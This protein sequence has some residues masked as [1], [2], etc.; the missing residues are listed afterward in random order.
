VSDGADAVPIKDRNER[1]SLPDPEVIALA[2]A[3]SV[4][5]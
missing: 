4:P 3:D 5:R 2:G 1:L